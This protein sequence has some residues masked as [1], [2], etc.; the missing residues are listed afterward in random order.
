MRSVAAS[1]I[2]V[3]PASNTVAVFNTSSWT[4][5][6]L[7]LLPASRS[8]AGDAVT[9]E[10]GAPAPSQRLS[11]GTLA[12]LASDIPAM[13]SRKFTV[14]AGT[15]MFQGAAAAGANTLGTANIA[16][17]FDTATGAIVSLKTR[18]ERAGS[19]GRRG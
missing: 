14:G 18:G 9:D 15:P 8:R 7:V 4:R 11:D 1:D 12:F 2:V 16:L 19:R 6:D 10:R 3:A 5:R 17:Q 13:S